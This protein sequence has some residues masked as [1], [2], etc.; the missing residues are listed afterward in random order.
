MNTLSTAY[1]IFLVSFNG[2][3]QHFIFSGNTPEELG[4][5]IQEHGKYGIVFIKRFNQSKSKFDSLSKDNIK[6][7]FSWDTHTI[8]QLEKI[9]FIKK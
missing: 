5:L 2:V 8:L 6:Q 3:S 1:G 9:N 4:N 7:L